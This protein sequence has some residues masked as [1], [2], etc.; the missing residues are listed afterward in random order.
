MAEKVLEIWSNLARYLKP[1]LV[2]PQKDKKE[3]KSED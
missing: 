3:F 1:F 2:I